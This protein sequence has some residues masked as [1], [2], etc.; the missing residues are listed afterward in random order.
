MAL[1]RAAYRR[2]GVAELT[3]VITGETRSSTQ[4][5]KRR[6]CVARAV[7]MGRITA[8]VRLTA[9]NMFATNEALALG[10]DAQRAYRTV[11]VFK[12]STNSRNCTTVFSSAADATATEVTAAPDL[13]SP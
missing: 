11:A 1:E 5:L 13:T 4:W 12:R 6:T 9:R 8:R 3:G 10:K 2:A 7:A